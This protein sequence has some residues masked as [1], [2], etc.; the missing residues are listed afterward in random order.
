MENCPL[1]AN[2]V[3][4]DLCS[5]PDLKAA[6]LTPFLKSLSSHFF[7]IR[8]APGE[9]I[10]PRGVQSDF[11]GFLRQGCVEVYDQWGAPSP[12][13]VRPEEC[14]SRPG[15]VLLRL[16]RWA[17][18]R[19]DRLDISASEA[20]RDPLTWRE[21]AARMVAHTLRWSLQRLEQWSVDRADRARRHRRGR[22]S[23]R[24][25][26]WVARNVF[27]WARR[28][29]HERRLA[30]PLANQAPGGKKHRKPIR[31]IT[32][33]DEAGNE[34]EVMLRFMGLTGALWNVPRSVT[35]V[36]QPDSEGLP[37]ELLMVKRNVLLE[38]E[39]RSMVFRDRTKER[40]L[41]AELALLLVENRL[42]RNTFA[43]SDIADWSG[44][45]DLLWGKGA[46]QR[47]EALQRIRQRLITGSAD[48]PR[49]IE[50]PPAADNDK[51]IRAP[52]QPLP[53]RECAQLPAQAQRPRFP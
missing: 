24:L 31:T 7:K 36:A 32:A 27:G 26:G 45:L 33:R 51:H 20:G 9:V 18:G 39:Q 46:T 17:I 42:F 22:W 53:D 11:A 16:E 34:Q 2:E 3:E 47:P 30:Q 1:E 21:R 12:A 13:Q 25:Q 48:F 19:T 28:R 37:C 49:W 43:E 5:L 14:W 8:Y 41:V 29:V 38:I 35:L 50:A 44:F 40:F 15:A 10:M 6:A 4:A 23:T 52:A